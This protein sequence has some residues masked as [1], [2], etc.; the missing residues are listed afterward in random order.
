MFLSENFTTRNMFH[1]LYV[2]VAC[3][4]VAAEQAQH[5]LGGRKFNRIPKEGELMID[6]WFNVVQEDSYNWKRVKKVQATFAL[7]TDWPKNM[8][9]YMKRVLGKGKYGKVHL[10]MDSS[11][12]QFALKMMFQDPDF[13]YNDD[14][15][16]GMTAREVMFEELRKQLDYPSGII[17]EGTLN[18]FPCLAMP[19]VAEISKQRYDELKSKVNAEERRLEVMGYFHTKENTA[20]HHYGLRLDTGGQEKYIFRDMEWLE[21]RETKAT[22]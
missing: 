4:C 10:C 5:T 14:P 9:V 21:K 15:E 11:G 8:K 13:I 22:E 3:A 1:A 6:E 7:K 18:G 16:T 2:A 19:F 20:W 12:H 17:W